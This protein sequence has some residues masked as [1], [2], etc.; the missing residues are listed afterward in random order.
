MVGRGLGG[1]EPGVPGGG[2]HL[3]AALRVGRRSSPWG[4]IPERLGAPGVGVRA[5]RGLTLLSA[6]AA[7]RGT[8]SG[9]VP[10][11]LVL[12]ALHHKESIYFPGVAGL[13]SLTWTL[14]GAAPTVWQGWRRLGWLQS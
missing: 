14:F 13:P 8:V 2:G 5:G 1:G 4:R 3:L 11:F 6:E 12:P 9:A 10:C 7:L